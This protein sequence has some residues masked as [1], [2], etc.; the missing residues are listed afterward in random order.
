M[1][2]TFALACRLLP[3]GVRDDV[4][5]LYLVFRT[6]DDLV[7]EQ[8]PDAAERVAAVEAWCA[9]G[10]GPRRARSRSSTTLAARHALPRD[11]LRDFCA[12]HAPG[13]RG[14]A[15]AHRGRP[16]PL[17]LPRRRTVGLVMA[18]H[19]RH[20][21]IA[22]APSRPPPRS[23]MAMQRT[24]ILRD[25]DED[26]ANGRV[27]LAAETIARCGALAPGRR[28]ALLR[29]QI[30]RADALYERGLRGIPQL[31]QGGRAVA[32]R[33]GDVP[34]DPAPD[35]ARGLRR[36]RAGGGPAAAQAR[37]RGPP[38]CGARWRGACGSRMS[39]RSNTVAPR[40]LA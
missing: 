37:R 38:G 40:R 17:L 22:A 29:D 25:I 11:A 19:A 32:A 24:N 30:A 6:L 16:R 14:D 8:R 4:Y 21:A 23:G 1:A 33:G 5:L 20:R 36:G 2:R 26:R 7:D 34:R 15:D 9:G 27:Y 39:R 3:R 12:G 31:R 28:E 18:A 13:P 35:R 10:A